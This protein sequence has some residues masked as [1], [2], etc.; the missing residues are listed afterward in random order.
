MKMSPTMT[1]YRCDLIYRIRFARSGEE[2]RRLIEAAF[3]SLKDHKVNGHLILRFVEKVTQDLG[4]FNPMNQDVQQWTNIETARMQL[5]E[6][7]QAILENEKEI[8]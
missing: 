3:K 2:V 4:G 1:E 6:L 8:L 5:N 7:K